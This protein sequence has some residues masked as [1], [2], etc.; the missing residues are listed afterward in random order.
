MIKR[1]PAQLLFLATFVLLVGCSSHPPSTN[2]NTANPVSASPSASTT[3]PASAS[4]VSATGSAKLVGLAVRVIDG[5]TIDVVDEQHATSRVRLQG[6]D[7]PEKRQA[8]GDVSRQNLVSL[9]AGKTVQVEWRK[10]DK[11]GRII[12]KVF[13]DNRDVCL[14]QV[15]AGLA[16]H[17]KEY[18]SEQS[19]IDQRV[20]AEAE[21]TARS[22][23]LGLWHDPSQIQP[24][25]FRHHK[26][27]TGGSST[28]D[29]SE[30]EPP[31]PSRSP[32]ATTDTEGSIRGNKHSKI[33]HWPGCPNYDDIYPQNR[34]A[35]RTREEAEK[36]GYRPAKNCP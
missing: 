13:L 6:I 22:Q 2:R 33:Y 35:F 9:V 36:A 17:Y 11:Y 10:H 34:V 27:G 19:E 20:Y 21:Q 12:G 4:Q 26:P 31:T 28:A 23:R 15:K 5:D 18:A 8:F 7:A 14:D 3:S 29:A 24:S 16:W 32:A 30:G 25:E 1:L